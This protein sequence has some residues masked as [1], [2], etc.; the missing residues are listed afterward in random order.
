MW[1]T[2]GLCWLFG[3]NVEGQIG[4]GMHGNGSNV[5]EPHLFQNTENALQKRTKIVDG[6]CGQFHTVLMTKSGGIWVFGQGNTLQSI[7]DKPLFIRCG[8]KNVVRV[9]VGCKETVVFAV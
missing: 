6:S 1:T 7:H 3:R 8:D 5:R 2:C 4:N 9:I